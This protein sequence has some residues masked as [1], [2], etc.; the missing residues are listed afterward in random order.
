MKWK[1]WGYVACIMAG[2]ALCAGVGYIALHGSGA[3]LNA[4]L[5]S[6]RTDLASAT[7]NSA[8]LAQQLR[9]VHQ[10]LDSAV[11]LADS[12]QRIISQQQSR[13]TEQQQLIDAGKRGLESI[14]QEI[15][16][17]GSDIGKQIRSLAEGLI[18]LY[19]I[20]HTSPG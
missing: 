4:D 19:A 3:K 9:L 1:G 2:I 5:A 16:G 8:D 13:L 7:A 10:Q 20:Y 6:L 12:E 18:R 14:A 15:A 17:S 11:G